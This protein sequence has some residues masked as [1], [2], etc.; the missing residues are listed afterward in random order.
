MGRNCVGLKFV[1]MGVSIVAVHSGVRGKK[2][3]FLPTRRH[4]M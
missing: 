3:M 1:T 2:Y 4:I